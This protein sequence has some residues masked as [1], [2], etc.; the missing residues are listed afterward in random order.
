[1]GRKLLAGCVAALAL[2]AGSTVALAQVGTEINYQGQLKEF[3]SSTN[4]PVDLEFRLFDTITGG[5]QVGTAVTATLTPVDGLFTRNLDFGV[6]PYVT[7]APRFLEIK[8]RSAGSGLFTT[9]PRQRLTAAPHSL[10]TR[11]MNVNSAGS[12][13]IGTTTPDNIFEVVAPANPSIGL[14]QFG[15]S[16]FEVAVAAAVANWSQSAAANDAVLRSS[17]GS[18]IHLLSGSGEAA[19]T[20]AGS[21]NVGIGTTAPDAKLQIDRVPDGGKVLLLNN[22]IATWASGDIF[23]SFRYIQT[24]SPLATDG[25]WKQFNVA[26]GGVSIGYPNT[27]V[28]NS[29]DAMYVNGSVGIGTNVPSH[30]LTVRGA[31]NTM[32]LIGPTGEF[33]WNSRMNLGDGG[34]VSISE[35]DDDF[36][37]LTGR[38][39]IRAVNTFSAPVK[40]FR[41]DH[42]SNPANMILNHG[43]IESDQYVNL[44]R[45]NAVIGNDGG[46]WIQLPSW[47]SDLNTDFSYQ[48]TSIG[49]AQPN[50]FVA[51]EVNKS[52]QFRVA[53]GIP[54]A[55]VSWQITGVRHDAYVQANPLIVE[56]VKQPKD[57][58]TYLSPN[59]F[60]V[61][62]AE[63][64]AKYGN[65]K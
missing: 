24:A 6:N 20:V 38:N 48:L 10:T 18:A 5:A 57:Q 13:G 9:L 50:L 52:N 4:A 41:I 44:Y 32:R 11:G 58:G 55:K 12:V 45:G 36:L 3:G 37:D 62:T 34:F 27:P 7:D 17:G 61:Y 56:E 51:V 26:P 43:C 21:N 28:Y 40:N 33:E 31:G 42:P 25:N 30:K 64:L 63:E 49:A 2:A 54:G 47:M 23:N 60:G 1:M 35:N 39:G 14:R 19:L 29:S 46:V 22:P 16:K 8:V 65:R 59:S 15:G 53:G